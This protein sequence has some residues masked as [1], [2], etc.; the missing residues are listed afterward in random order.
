MTLLAVLTKC[1][2]AVRVFT[3]IEVAFNLVF[4]LVCLIVRSVSN[5]SLGKVNPS[6]D[7]LIIDRNRYASVLN[8][9]I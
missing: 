1:K 9:R 7:S 8:L 4:L 5:S 6:S 3:R 2:F